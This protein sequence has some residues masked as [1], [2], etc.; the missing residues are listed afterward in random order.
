MSSKSLQQL[1]R[2]E[3]LAADGKC[4]PGE[5]FGDASL[6][7]DLLRDPLEALS[8]ATQD[9]SGREQRSEWNSLESVLKCLCEPQPG[10]GTLINRDSLA[11][12]WLN[13]LHAAGQL[14]TAAEAWHD[15]KPWGAIG[16]SLQAAHGDLQRAF[17]GD[18]NV[19]T[20]IADNSHSPILSA[21]FS[22]LNLSRGNMVAEIMWH[23]LEQWRCADRHSSPSPRC[24]VHTPILAGMGEE[25]TVL[26]LQV[27]LFPK[28]EG[29]RGVLIPDLRCLGLRVVEESCLTAF[30]EVWT[31]TNLGRWVTGVWSIGSRIP[32]ELLGAGLFE[33]HENNFQPTLRGPSAQA[34]MLCTLLAATGIPDSY[35]P[36]QPESP[37]F[38][39]E[40]LLPSVAISAAVGAFNHEKFKSIR[41]VPLQKVGKLAAKAHAAFQ[42]GLRDVLFVAEQ[43]F[44]EELAQTR[45]KVE[46]ARRNPGTQVYSGLWMEEVATVEDAINLML[47]SNKYQRQYADSIRVQWEAQWLNPYP[48]QASPNASSP[49]AATSPTA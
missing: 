31:M 2:L 1:R 13:L 48:E 47:V 37:G 33:D 4:T 24:T 29:C 17:R 23:V 30:R 27:D 3:Q 5:V 15:S 7:A 11:K 26:W 12:G 40:S 8:R 10:L 45:A 35:E 32:K 41:D 19:V 21:V 9:E 20:G 34:A 18:S 43:P 25:G 42:F 49:T 14:A 22:K 16:E 38:Q 28:P 39:P 46:Q 36:D 6:L 44:E